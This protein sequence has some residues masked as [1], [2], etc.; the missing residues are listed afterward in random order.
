MCLDAGGVSVFNSAV[1]RKLTS[2]GFYRISLGKKN[3][4]TRGLSSMPTWWVIILILLFK[5]I[6]KKNRYQSWK[7][8]IFNFFSCQQLASS[9]K[10]VKLCKSFEGV[11]IRSMH[12]FVVPM[13]VTW[14]LSCL[15]VKKLM[16][17]LFDYYHRQQFSRRSSIMAQSAFNCVQEVFI[18]M[19]L[20]KIQLSIGIH[21]H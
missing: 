12:C 8:C 18:V 17:L 9:L 3:C 5:S 21:I 19:P 20:T 13:K 14:T 15:Q 4:F 7:L 1:G 11:C 16:F 2:S 6:L 10:S